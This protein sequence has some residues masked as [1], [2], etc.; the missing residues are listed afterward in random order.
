MTGWVGNTVGYYAQDGKM[1]CDPKKAGGNVYTADEY[2]DFSFRFEFKLTPGANNGLGIRAPLEGDAAYAGMEIQILDDTAPQYA[3]LQPY[4]YHGSIYGTVPA[5]RGHLKPVGEWNYEEVIAKGRQITVKL[6]GETIV[7]ADIDRASTPETMDHRDHPGL[8]RT[9]GHIGFCGH[10]DY[11]S[12]ATSGSNRWTESS[13][14]PAG[15][16]R[17]R[18]RRPAVLPLVPSLPFSSRFPHPGHNLRI[19]PQAFSCTKHD[20]IL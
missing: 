16:R 2:G 10:G 18:R 19:M 1:I 8:K 20:R 9:R 4:Q 14:M 17:C 13:H 12:S 15:R 11:L 5:K 6:N 7:D 3:T